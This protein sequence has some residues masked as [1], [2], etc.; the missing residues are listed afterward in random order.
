MKIAEMGKY[1]IHAPTSGGKAG[2]GNNRTSTVQVRLGNQ[3]KKQIRYTVGKPKA[4]ELAIDKARSF[5]AR[6]IAAGTERPPAPTHKLEFSSR[7]WEE[8][9]SLSFVPFTFS[10]GDAL[11]RAQWLALANMAVGKAERI[12]AGDYGQRDEAEGFDPAAWSRDLRGIAAE[13]LANFKPGDGKF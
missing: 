10:Q 11:T 5:I 9:E 3:L 4:R 1:E 8:L 2:K 13:I 6:Q 7:Q 12:D